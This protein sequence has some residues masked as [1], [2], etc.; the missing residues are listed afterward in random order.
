LTSSPPFFSINGKVKQLIK[1][2]FPKFLKEPYEVATIGVIGDYASTL[3]GLSVGC[4]ETHPTYSPLNA[5]LFWFIILTIIRF[6]FRKSKY[7]EKIMTV[8]SI[9]SLYGVIHNI[10]YLICLA[11]M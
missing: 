11:V 7:Q 2:F 6:T 4:Y 3:I 9:L 10:L 1:F 5:A 8:F